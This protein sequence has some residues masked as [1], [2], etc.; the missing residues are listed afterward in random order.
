MLYIETNVVLCVNY[1]EIKN[2]KINSATL[3]NVLKLVLWFKHPI[4]FSTSLLGFLIGITKLI[5]PKIKSSSICP[6]SNVSSFS[7]WYHHS[8]SGSGQ[9]SWSHPCCFFFSHPTSK[10]SLLA[11]LSKFIPNLVSSHHLDHYLLIP[12]IIILRVHC[13]YYCDSTLTSLCFC[14]SATITYSPRQ[15]EWTF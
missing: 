6:S 8:S 2:N 5:H 13:P 12:S 11:L 4:I 9:K 1:A 3:N 15:L 7:K 14:S 10:S